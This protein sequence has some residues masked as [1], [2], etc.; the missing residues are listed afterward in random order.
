MVKHETRFL[1]IVIIFLITFQPLSI[2]VKGNH[3][4][5][6]GYL[7]LSVINTLAFTSFPFLLSTCPPFFTSHF[8][9]YLSTIHHITSSSETP[10]IYHQLFHFKIARYLTLRLLPFPSNKNHSQPINLV[11][12]TILN[13]VHS[14]NSYNQI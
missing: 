12:S 4:W 14:L 9:L 2:V 8:I 10:Y 13:I 7:P 11:V 6:L 1:F 3:C 5:L